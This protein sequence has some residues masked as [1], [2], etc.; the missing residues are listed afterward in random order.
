MA[1]GALA[2]IHRRS[3]TQ[4]RFLE[5]AERLIVE[6]GY[7]AITTRSLAEA[8]GLN[9]GLVHYHFG[10]I[11][12]LLARVLARF[13]E[14]LI[15]RQRAL[16]A[17]DVPFPQKWRQAMRYLDED[18]ES[19]YQKMW[20]ELQA[21]AWNRPALRDHVTRVHGEWRAVL[22]EAFERARV[23]LALEV[24]V[25]VLVALVMTFNEGIILE[26]LSGVDSGHRELLAWIDEQLVRAQ[27]R[28]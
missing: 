14:R 8:A 9:A 21:L 18:R 20:L 7:A 22:R 11:E 4:E 23:E 27:E 19:G 26:R 3:E 28:S 16:Y 10:S 13:T 6:S 24:P 2:E 5:A 25:D 1:T 15:E 12:Q 17:A